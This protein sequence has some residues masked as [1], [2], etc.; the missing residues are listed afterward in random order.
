MPGSSSS[1][2]VHAVAVQLVGVGDLGDQPDSHLCGEVKAVTKVVVARPVKGELAE[3]AGVPGQ[4]A[5]G[6]SSVVGAF[7][8]RVL[9]L[10]LCLRC[11][12]C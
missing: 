9:A 3:G 11:F 2:E 1:R 4:M 6:V 10:C 7:E 12:R 8:V 5:D